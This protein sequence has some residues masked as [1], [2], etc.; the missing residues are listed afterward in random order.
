ML[1]LLFQT[2]VRRQRPVW[3]PVP[4]IGGGRPQ[5]EVSRVRR[6]RAQA[7]A[8]TEGLLR[9]EEAQQHAKRISL[10]VKTI[11]LLLQMFLLF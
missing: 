2:L 4:S 7:L 8:K 6:G 1:N 11:L 9:G 10:Q 3:P 5:G